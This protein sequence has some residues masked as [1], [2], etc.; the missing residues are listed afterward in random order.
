MSSDLA[1]ARR[2]AEEALALP[3]WH[4]DREAALI[5]ALNGF[6]ADAGVSGVLRLCIAATAPAPQPEAKASGLAPCPFCGA[7]VRRDYGADEHDPPLVCVECGYEIRISSERWNER[8]APPAGDGGHVLH[9]GHPHGVWCR[10]CWP[11]RPAGDGEPVSGPYT[12]PE[13]VRAFIDWCASGDAHTLHATS[14]HHGLN[15]CLR[16]RAKALAAAP[17]PAGDG[18]REDAEELLRE[19]ADEMCIVY[20]LE[21]DC[22]TARPDK[23]VKW[24]VTCRA[25][26]WLDAAKGGAR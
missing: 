15:P 16:C 1:D 4:A 21:T 17:K 24:C 11:D 22:R 2:Q 19:I 12:L 26:A 25:R 14:C 6:V 8:P 20:Y 23:P 3:G 13:G 7:Q 10:L 9:E 18:V 5:R